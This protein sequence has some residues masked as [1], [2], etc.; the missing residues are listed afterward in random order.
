MESTSQLLWGLLFGSIGVGFFIY[1]RK[2]KALMPFLVGIALFALPYVF[3]SAPALI[4]GGLVLVA[5]PYFV[6]L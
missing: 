1:G 2:Q 4:L 6:R 3:T 5:L